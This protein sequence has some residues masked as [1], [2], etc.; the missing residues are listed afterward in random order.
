MLGIL[1]FTLMLLGFTKFFTS[2]NSTQNKLFFGVIGV[3]VFVSIYWN[4]EYFD[5]MYNYQYMFNNIDS[6]NTDVIFTSL[7][8][9]ANR[10]GLT[11]EDLYNFHIVIMALFF[12]LFASRFSNNIIVILALICV[13][14]YVDYGNQI[15]FYMGFFFILNALYEYLVK[16]RKISSIILA[17][18]AILCH[19]SLVVL[20]L[21]PFF[22]DFLFKLSLKRTIIINIILLVFFNFLTLI[23]SNIFPQFLKYFTEEKGKSSIIG[24]VFELFP[25]IFVVWLIVSTHNYVFRVNRSFYDNN[26]YR[27]L[28]TLCNFS[29]LFIST[30]LVFRILANRFVLSFSLVWICYLLYTLNMYK[31][32][33][34]LIQKF[35]IVTYF[36]ILIFWFYYAS[37]FVL[38]SSYNLEEAL[39]MLQIN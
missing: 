2:P 6:Y 11:F 39:K 13:F 31:K 22:K 28:Y 17:I 21:I 35:K 37:L 20:L 8:R 34:V 27:F 18:L 10:I 38:G 4:I 32:G 12:C 9:L 3:L 5:D 1:F 15:R 24:G 25:L 26:N 23:I 33:D 29:F 14:R 16:E 30:G 36:V 19:S 7:V